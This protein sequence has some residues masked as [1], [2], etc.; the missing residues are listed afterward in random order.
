M[1]PP[2]DG[3]HG[4][5]GRLSRLPLIG[6]VVASP[7]FRN[8]D[9]RRLWSGVACNAFGMS[10][11]QVILGLL[12]FRITGS[13]A[14]VG[15]TLAL[16]NLPMLVFGLLSGAAA[17]WL[18]RRTLLRAIELAIALNLGLF[19][20]VIGTGWVGLWPI[21]AF[22]AITGSLRS[23]TQPVRVSYAYDIVGGENV[24]AGLG[25]LN[26]GTR[27]GQLAGALT[28]GVV[29]E[30]IGTPAALLV[31][32]A[33][34][35]AAFVMFSLLRSAGDS[36]PMERAPIAQN[37]REYIAEMRGNR[38]L[39]MLVVVT[40]SV[41]VFGF[42]FSTALPELATTRFGLGAEGLGM[43]HAARAAGG[44]LAGL[45]LAGA[46]SFRRRGTVYLAVI[47][48]FGASLLLL[49]AS[50]AFALGLAALV[51]VAALA[52]TSDILT[53]SMMQLSVPNRLRGRAMGAW[54]FAIGSSPLG[55][56]E[57]GALAVSLG[58]GS[59]LVINGAALIGIGVLATIVA[60]RL[61]RL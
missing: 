42:S 14:W 23:M 20:I 36:A 19:A 1:A 25:L 10:G 35:G 6:P 34:H 58:V 28:A 11:E 46:G 47:Y 18:D 40:A 38:T 5:L 51:A 45:V 9:F 27:L 31:L 12:V 21:L 32:A 41:E 8:A 61:R 48:A 57:M 30:R 26:L 3:A 43:M 55:H 7:A 56:L 53:Q 4:R 17:D 33:I 2:R 16:Y 44:V 49:A 59:A 60:P 22:T 37:L 29:M 15:V 50:D 39:V 52:T 54:V 13:T 24:I